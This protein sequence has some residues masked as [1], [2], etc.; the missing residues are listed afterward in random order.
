MLT[1]EFLYKHWNPGYELM[2]ERDKKKSRISTRKRIV[3]ACNLT[4]ETATYQWQKNGGV[5]PRD[6]AIEIA[7]YDKT[8]DFDV[9]DYQTTKPGP[10][11]KNQGNAVAA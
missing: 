4:T 5:I 7:I 8:I 3:E 6:R 1:L 10:K 9:S 2:Q 11:P